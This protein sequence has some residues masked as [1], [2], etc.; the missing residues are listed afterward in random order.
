M[1]RALAVFRAITVTRNTLKKSSEAL[2]NGPST[3]TRGRV[4]L[5]GGGITTE[6]SP[7]F[8][9]FSPPRSFFVKSHPRALANADIIDSIRITKTRRVCKQQELTRGEVTCNTDM[10]RDVV[11]F[12]STRQSERTGVEHEIQ[13]HENLVG[14]TY[15]H[16]Q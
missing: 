1:I 6:P 15:C 3:I 14:S 16:C 2:P 4:R 10:H 12:G 8:E 13:A 7:F 11:L 9:S 5:S